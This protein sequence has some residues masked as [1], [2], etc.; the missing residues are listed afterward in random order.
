MHSSRSEQ[1]D[2]MEKAMS[3]IT[4]EVFLSCVQGGSRCLGFFV[5]PHPGPLPQGEREFGHR[6]FAC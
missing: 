5:S 4:S 2:L 1:A 6:I 3:V